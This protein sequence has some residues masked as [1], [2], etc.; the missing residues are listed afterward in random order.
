MKMDLASGA[1][2]DLDGVL[3]DSEGQYSEFWDGMSKIY[4]TGIDNFA[5]VIKGTTL[6][7][8]LARHFPSDE[9]KAD[10]IKRLETFERN[11]QFP[12]IPGALDFI[13]KLHQKGIPMAIVTSSAPPKM[14]LLFERYPEFTRLFDY[15]V[16]DA[17]VTHSK[18]HPEPYLIG[19]ARIGKSPSDC[20]VF[21]DSAN[22]L[23]AGMAAGCHVVGLTTTLPHDIVAA[24][25]HITVKDFTDLTDLI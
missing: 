20:W 4:D 14:Q 8:I 3:I 17:D 25:S 7:Q 1:L 18:P 21:E 11:M 23:A 12:L 19:A 2:F 16:T 15:V 6:D 22:G 13:R 9:V 5:M 10:I 24:S